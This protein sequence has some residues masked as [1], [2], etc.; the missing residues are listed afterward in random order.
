MPGDLERGRLKLGWARDR[1]AV[2]GEIRARFAAE[3]PFRGLTVSMVLHVEAKTG[4][5]ALAV[6]EGGANV[7]LAA[8]NPLSTD[9]DV[10][11]ALLDAGVTT[12]AVKG[13]SVAEYS[14][15][16][17]A[18]L[19]ADPDVIVDDG[20]DLVALAHTARAD[21]GRI[22]GSTEETTTGITR[23]RALEKS[24]KLRFPA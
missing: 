11:R 9:D 6:K 1:M 16:V 22:R 7:H 13:E 21:R 17:T 10:V 15:G 12:H 3:R 2:L 24:G 4:V 20:A 8:G 18:M 14:A 23:L 19:D 5:L